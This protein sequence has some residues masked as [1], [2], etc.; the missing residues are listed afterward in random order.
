[1]TLL[2]RLRAETRP[3]HE[4]TEALFYTEALQNGTLSADE[5]SHLLR[6]HLTFHQALETAIERH[7]DFFQDYEL[8][9][10][11]KTQWLLDD[12]AHLNESLPD[13]QP[14]LFVEWS[15]MALL[16][17]AYVSE[18]SMLGGTVIGR[19]LQKNPAI[20]PLLS[21]ARFYQGYGQLTGINWKNFGAFAT[22]QGEAHAD[23]VVAA[24]KQAFTDYQAIFE[25]NRFTQEVQNTG[26]K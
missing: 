2:E 3:Q 1:M 22:R 26:S 18:G 17:A 25:K 20:Q 16:G 21:H 15:P 12:L 4:Q 11:R 9:S 10:R 5:Y 6:T 14:E 7:P 24:A 23:E 8:D 13:L 19:L